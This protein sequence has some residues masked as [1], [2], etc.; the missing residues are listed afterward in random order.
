VK[1]NTAVMILSKAFRLNL[2]QKYTF[3]VAFGVLTDS[4]SVISAYQY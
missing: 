2:T 3:W 4:N 1:A